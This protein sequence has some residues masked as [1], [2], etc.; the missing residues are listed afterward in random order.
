MPVPTTGMYGEILQ[1]FPS[2]GRTPTGLAWDGNS[3]W[4]A[5]LATK[6]IYQIDP[7]TGEV[8][9][10]VPAPNNAM[11][12][13]LEWDGSH[14]WCSDFLNNCLYKLDVSD[15]SI[16]R[17]I[18]LNSEAPQGMTFHGGHLLCQDSES[19]KI[20]KLDINT[21]TYADSMMTVGG[22]KDNLGIAWDG[23]YL[24]STDLENRVLCMIDIQRHQII[25]LLSSPGTYPYGLTFD[26]TDL[27]NVD[28]QTDTI[29]KISIHGGEQHQIYDPLK[30]V[31]RY[32]A[33]I[34]NVGTTTMN[35]MTFYPIPIETVYQ[36]LDNSIHYNEPPD[37]FMTDEYGQLIAMYG[38]SNLEPG[39]EIR[40]QWSVPTTL[41]NIRYFLHPDSVGSL[42]MVPDSIMDVYTK[43]GDKYDIHDPVIVHAVQ[44]AIG[45]E[46]NLYWQVRNIHD[47]VI[48]H[49]DYLNDSGWGTAPQIL[50]QGHGS[51]SEYSFL[52]IAMC[53]AAGI[54]ARFEAGGHLRSDIPYEDTVFHRWQQVYFP[55]YGWI[56]LDC[57]WD[58]KDTHVKQSLFFGATANEAFTTTIGG[59][60]DYGLWWNY[61]FAYRTSGGRRE[62]FRLMEWLPY[63][64][65]VE[66]A[67][68]NETAQSTIA[69]NYPNPFNSSTIISYELKSQ[70]EVSIDIFNQLGQLARSQDLNVQKSGRHNYYWNGT[71]S[72]GNT[73]SSGVY[74]YRIKS[75]KNV[76]TGRMTFLR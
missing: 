17:T 51:C 16:V 76:H 68:E 72:Y 3:L 10:A 1:S 45:D 60:G 26:G 6:T 37:N 29:Y 33:G 65:S 63:T 53:R 74:F 44:E 35:M 34:K 38:W 50:E 70:S 64:T 14:L 39:E 57:T 59:G 27:W 41:Y 8:K 52:F 55:N 61:N 36:Q 25:R 5:D 47:Y 48:S 24:W 32:T 71:D 21:E 28:F 20:Y 4:S 19:Q 69:C 23:A 2:P 42:D 49:I 15:G 31:I 73:V 56:P 13:A 66:L 40:H 58:D 12:S 9:Y 46:T 67:V 7:N 30:V 43:D 11:I 18:S 75:S 54:P 62:R 22:Y